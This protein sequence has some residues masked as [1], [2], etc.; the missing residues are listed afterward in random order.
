MTEQ[1][2]TE[3]ILNEIDEQVVTSVERIANK[4]GESKE[5]VQQ[6]IE[7]L[8]NQKIIDAEKYAYLGKQYTYINIKRL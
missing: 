2:L 1:P 8:W 4:L 7:T 5:E 3:R 6:V